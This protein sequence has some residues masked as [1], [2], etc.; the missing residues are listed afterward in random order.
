MFELRKG[1]TGWR[2]KGWDRGVSGKEK[3]GVEEGSERERVRA[4]KG[5]AR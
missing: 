5:T 4:R 1:D 3:G 2:V